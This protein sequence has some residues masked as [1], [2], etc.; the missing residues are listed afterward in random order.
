M[1]AD[2]AIKCSCTFFEKVHLYFECVLGSQP[3][4]YIILRCILPIVDDRQA[5]GM[6]MY[7]GNLGYYTITE[8]SNLEMYYEESSVVT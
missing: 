6:Q 5:V 4:G 2:K 3:V 8:Y 1:C 7:P